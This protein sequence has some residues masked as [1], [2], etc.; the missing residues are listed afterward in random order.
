MEQTLQQLLAEQVSAYALSDRPRELIDEGID[1]LFKD[2]VQDA[3]RSYG[4]FGSAIKEAVK[5]AL[6]ANV[7]DMFELQR[8]NALIANSLSQRWEAAALHSVIIEQADK[9]ITELL[10]GDGLLTGEVSLN[11]LINAFID[12]HK[13]QA[14]EE[15][16]DRPEIRI[17]EGDS[18]GTSNKFL[19]IY[20]DPQ[21]EESARSGYRSSARSDYELKHSMHVLIKGA[22]ETSDHFRKSDEFGEVYSASLDEKKVSINMQ[23]RSEWQRLVASLYFGNAL[24]VIDCDPDDFSYGFD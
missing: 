20:F 2:V 12:A 11:K 9:S 23:V 18:Y 17:T 7:G 3:F 15:R 1:K 10:T 8:Y 24:L 21:S 6:P 13:D 16:W 22:R 14:A 19:H 4:D 5:S